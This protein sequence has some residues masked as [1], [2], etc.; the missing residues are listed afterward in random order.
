MQ[1]MADAFVKK[2][3]KS[4]LAEQTIMMLIDLSK[5]FLEKRLRMLL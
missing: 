5:I 2:A 3:M 4:F 1:T